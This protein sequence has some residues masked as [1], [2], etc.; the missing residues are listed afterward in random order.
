MNVG[1][2]AVLAAGA[3]FIWAPPCDGCMRYDGRHASGTN[4]PG[5]RCAR[6]RRA[7]PRHRRRRPGRARHHNPREDAPPGG[8]WRRPAPLHAARAPRLSRREL[9]PTLGSHPPRR[10][11]GLRDH[12][13]RRISGDVRHEH[14]LHRHRAARDR[15]RADARASD[16]ADT[17]GARRLD[18]RA[19]RV[20]PRQGDEC[21]LSER[22]RLCRLP[23]SRDRSAAAR[24][25][26]G[27]RRVRR[28]V[29]R[30]RRCHRLGLEADARRGTRHRAHHRDDQG[31]GARAAPGDASRGAGV[32]WH[33][34]RAALWAAVARRCRHEE[35]RHGLHGPV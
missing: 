10:G 33:H 25:G 8:A 6:R 13:A 26:D 32:R 22:P 21:H 3:S 15:Y 5:R 16:G 34:N 27:G 9:Q 4:D 20:R 35:R 18:P 2:R 31:G 7:R 12:G 30:N 24:D 29:L 28:D 11:R 19:R 23:R 17:G 14:D 1:R